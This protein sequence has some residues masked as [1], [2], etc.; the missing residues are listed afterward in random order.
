ME[1]PDQAHWTQ[2][3]RDEF[4][5]CGYVTFKSEAEV[6]AFCEVMWAEACSELDKT[7]GRYRV[8]P[9]PTVDM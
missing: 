7:D 5:E 8:H 1:P 4:A 9:P 2:E 3:E 6:S